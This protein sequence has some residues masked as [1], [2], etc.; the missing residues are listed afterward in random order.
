MIRFGEGTT[1]VDITCYEGVDLSV[2]RYCS[3]A[4]GLRI[5]SGQHP[6][7]AHPEAV[8]QY[9]LAE[10]HPGIDYWPSDPGGR[11]QIGN[12]VWVGEDVHILAGITVGDGAVVGACSVVAHN[13]PS[14]AIVIGNPSRLLRYRFDLVTIDELQRIAWWNWEP[15]AVRLAAP[16][17]KDVAGFVE[18][19]T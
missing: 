4:S 6:N 1:P 19:F 3:I 15:E 12:D 7:V 13:V 14:Y 18:R 8:T 2:G 5:V 10:H 11:V 17:M 9:P 16:Y